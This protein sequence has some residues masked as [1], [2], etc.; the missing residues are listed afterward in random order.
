M[1]GM[2]GN[3]IITEEWQMLLLLAVGIGIVVFIHKFILRRVARDARRDRDD[4]GA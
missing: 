4:R 2:P 1:P 3:P